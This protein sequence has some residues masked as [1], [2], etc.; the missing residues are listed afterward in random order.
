MEIK[1]KMKDFTYR[2]LKY[3]FVLLKEPMKTQSA[4][5]LLTVKLVTILYHPKIK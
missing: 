5:M 1:T 2:T 4:T 3:Y